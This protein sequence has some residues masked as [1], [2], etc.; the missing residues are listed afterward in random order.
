MSN[1]ASPAGRQ[2]SELFWGITVLAVLVGV[3]VETFLVYTLLKFRERGPSEGAATEKGADE[4]DAEG[5]HASEVHPTHHGNTKVEV[6]LTA[7]TAVAFAGLVVFSW[8]T[9]FAIET[10]P[11]GDS[12]T[13]EVIGHQ[14]AWEFYY[15][16]EDITE[17]KALS[18]MHVPVNKIVKLNVTSTDVAHAASIPDLAVMVDAYPN[19]VNHAWFIAEREG[20]FLLQCR[21]FCGLAHSNMHAVV[22][23]QSQAAF[24]A[25]VAAKR[26]AANPPPPPLSTGDV[27]TV[28]LS[29]Y[30][31]DTSRP[32]LVDL[33]ANVTIQIVNN[34]SM[35]HAFALDAPYSWSSPTLNAGEN[36]TVNVVFNLSV[37]N[38]S[39]FCPIANHRR[40][41]MAGTFNVTPAARIIDVSIREVK[42][43]HGGWSISPEI[44]ELNPGEV[45][46]FR[47][48]NNL[49]ERNSHNLKIGAPYNVESPVITP[50]NSTFTPVIQVTTSAQ[51]WCAVSGHLEAGM[52][53]ELRVGG[54]GPAPETE[55]VPGFDL[56]SVMPAISVAA[57]AVLWTRERRKSR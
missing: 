12:L 40:L 50:G 28:T 53:G 49:T 52:L 15:P 39:F 27:L 5:E 37:E 10:P 18:E 13:V 11:E 22:V 57:V 25:W 44:I 17:L 7:I 45:V 29:D 24:D 36:I 51:Y 21:E 1:P 3:I 19:R 8:G 30:R 6:G 54:S 56:T 38:G 33:D 41:G 16:A 42:G 9:L 26:A 14:W 4:A 2:I 48:H 31:I 46:K 47:V 35:T 20:R 34:G 32:L 23:V 43:S 55:S